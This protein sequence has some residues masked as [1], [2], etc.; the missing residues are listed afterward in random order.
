MKQIEFIVEGKPVPYVR[1]TQKQ[2]FYCRQW[3]R[4]Q[5]YKKL[6]QIRFKKPK[7]LENDIGPYVIVQ[8]KYYE[9]MPESNNLCDY[10]GDLELSVKIFN[11]RRADASN[12]GKGVEDALNKVAYYDDRQIVKISAEYSQYIK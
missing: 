7:K 8:I 4:Y 6:V 12:I 11:Y 10:R 1:T 2:K 3:M 9:P 5:S